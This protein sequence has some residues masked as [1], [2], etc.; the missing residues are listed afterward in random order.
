MP[1][2]KSYGP[3]WGRGVFWGMRFLYLDESG[4]LGR[5]PVGDKKIQPLHVIAGLIV[6]QLVVTKITRDWVNLKRQ[7]FPDAI[8]VDSRGLDWHRFEVKGS[9]LRAAFREGGKRRRRHSQTVL[10]RALQ[11]LLDSKCQFVAHVYVKEPGKPID[12]SALYTYSVQA[13]CTKFHHVLEQNDDQGIVIADSRMPRP[14]ALVSHSVFTQKY[15][16]TGDSLPRILEAPVFG[17]SNNHAG[18]QLADLLASALL[19]PICGHAFL[20][21]FHDS[22]HVSPAYEAMGRRYWSVLRKLM[23]PLSKHRDGWDAVTVSNPVSKRG[24]TYLMR[25]YRDATVEEPKLCLHNSGESTNPAGDRASQS[26][27][28]RSGEHGQSSHRADV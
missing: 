2:S 13:A 1:G 21:G 12:G 15:K 14:N 3:V 22:E 20:S 18:L 17:H 11:V 9:A 5:L 8:P 19:F 24:S 25:S 10:D 28:A 16:Q 7:F 27:P 6:P 23:V 26:D 4:C